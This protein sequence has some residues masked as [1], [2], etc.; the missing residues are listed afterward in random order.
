MK[1][2]TKN[3]FG[4]DQ[5]LLAIFLE[6]LFQNMHNKLIFQVNKKKT[7]LF[8]LLCSW[9]NSSIPRPKHS[10][11]GQVKFKNPHF[12]GLIQLQSSCL[13]VQYFMSVYNKY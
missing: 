8:L 5:V 7:F 9:D 10:W 6:F 1:K 13:S 11:A 4:I 2:Q 3:C 12:S